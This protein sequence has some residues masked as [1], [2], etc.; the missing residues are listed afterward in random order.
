MRSL[1]KNKRLVALVLGVWFSG[2][3][4]VS[5]AMLARHLVPLPRPSRDDV[6]LAALLQPVR[7]ELGASPRWSAVHVLYTSCKCS[8]RI[9]DHLLSSQRPA[10]VAETVL[11]VGTDAKLSDKL[12]A[13]GFRVVETDANELEE[14]YHVKAVPLLVVFG[15]D[16][17]VRYAGGY[18]ERKQGPEPS[19]LSIIARARTDSTLRALPVFGCAVA[20]ELRTR[21]DPTGVL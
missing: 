21:L 6:A 17:A 15:A 10:D 12:R 1:K 3:V 16:S 11:L 14:R 7:G 20:E 8:Q 19:D 4:L 5:A 9:A 18:T 2:L 13:R